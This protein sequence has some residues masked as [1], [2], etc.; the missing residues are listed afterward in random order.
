H[1]GLYI[2]APGGSLTH[3]SESRS[4]IETRAS[5]RA[6]EISSLYLE[7]GLAVVGESCPRSPTRTDLTSSVSRLSLGQRRSAVRHGTKEHVAAVRREAVRER[8]RRRPPRN[9]AQIPA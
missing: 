1:P 2:A 5:R 3:D 4:E 8:G 9:A 6:I 7:S